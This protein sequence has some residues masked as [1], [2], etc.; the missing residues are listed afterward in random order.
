[1]FRFTVNPRVRVWIRPYV[2]GLVLGLVFIVRANLALA[3]QVSPPVS[4][5]QADD[6]W[7]EAILSN[8][9]VPVGIRVGAVERMVQ[10]KDDAI[11]KTLANALRDGD[12][13]MLQVIS[14]GIRNAQFVT[15]EVL[16]ATIIHACRIESMLDAHASILRQGGE[17]SIAELRRAYVEG[18]LA[19]QL[20]AIQGL[21]SINTIAS[22]EV[23]IDMVEVVSAESKVFAAIDSALQQHADDNTSRT[24]AGWKQWWTSGVPGRGGQNLELLEARIIRSEQRAER[25]EGRAEKLARRLVQFI[26]TALASMENEARDAK[27]IELASDEEFLIRQEAV[28]QVDQ[29]QLNGLAPSEELITSMIVLFDDEQ[30]E[31]RIDALR[32]LDRMNIKDLGIRVATALADEDNPEVQVAMLRFLGKKPIP[33][34]TRIVVDALQSTFP[35]VRDAAAQAIGSSA[36]AGF[37]EAD[38]RATVREVLGDLDIDSRALGSLAIQMSE[39]DEEKR[40]LLSSSNDLVRQGAAESL[41]VLGMRDLLTEMIDDP[42]VSKIALRAWTDP[43]FTLKSM[44][45]LEIFKPEVTQEEEYALWME[46]MQSVLSEMIAE[47]VVEADL[48]Y[49]GQPEFFSASRKALARVAQGNEGSEELRETVLLHLARRLIDEDLP[50]DAANVI[51]AVGVE[52]GSGLESVLFESLL[53][54]ESWDVAASVR[55]EPGAWMA[56]VVKENLG[57]PEWTRKLTE[58]IDMRFVANLSPEQQ[59]I[60]D[61]RRV[62]G[63]PSST[64]DEERAT[65]DAET[66]EDADSSSE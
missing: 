18:D 20:L 30:S 13:R 59:K 46:Y 23:L 35:Q 64:D 19:C 40:R 4:D 43:P 51:R 10:S 32:V 36:A 49:A 45:A 14:T 57:T 42:I 58:Q 12:D 52:P 48:R 34:S 24:A 15:P 29:M 41:R 1:M 39:G 44:D 21:G 27:I 63:L 17:T 22:T 11:L 9:A 26:N 66:I 3:M 31:I 54:G 55:S 6:A 60:L 47:E 61:G 62:I 25:A 50:L 8:E 28:T 65:A 7:F 37:L 33:E 5:Q 56:V 38:L 2:A 16:S 53:L